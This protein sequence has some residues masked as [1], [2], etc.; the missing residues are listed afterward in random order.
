MKKNKLLQICQLFFEYRF[1][2]EEG[3]GTGGT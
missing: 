3:G 2:L 1:I